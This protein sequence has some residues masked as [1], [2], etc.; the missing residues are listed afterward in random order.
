MSRESVFSKPKVAGR[1]T[2]Q[3]TLSPTHVSYANTLVRLMMT[4]VEVVGFRADIGEDGLTTDVSVEANSTPMTNEM[5]AHRIGLLPVYF[6]DPSKWEPDE[7]EFVLD[8]VNDSDD[9][10]D[11]KASD[12]KV[13]RVKDGDMTPVPW[14]EFFHPDP[15]TGDTCLLAQL[16]PKHVTGKPEEI[17]L[18]AKASVG[19]GRENAR[20]IPTSQCTYVYTQDTDESHIQEAM[21]TWLLMHKKID[22]P[23]WDEMTAEQKAPLEREFKT[24]AIKRCYLKNELG[25]PYSFDFTV[26]SVGV[27]TPAEIVKRGCEAG[28]RLCARFADQGG[29]SLPEDVEVQPTSKRLLGFDFVF[30]AQDHTLGNLLQTWLDQN[31]IDTG[32][33]TFAGYKIPHPLRDEMVLTI[34]VPDGQEATARRVL[35]EAASA[36]AAMFR[37]WSSQWSD[38]V[39]LATKQAPVTAAA[40]AAK[41]KRKIIRPPVA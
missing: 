34:G 11:V 33:V 30:Q 3:F 24:L 9:F 22:K 12:F 25:E 6:K 1:N 10:L 37:T 40:T 36:C 17:R 7:Y 19:V 2:I 41:P 35:K 4:G 29:E 8:V 32:E 39:G 15:V 31:K 23:Q 18:K 5:L 20:F 13:M 26:E 21:Q 14:R 27:L 16:K 28:A 38:L